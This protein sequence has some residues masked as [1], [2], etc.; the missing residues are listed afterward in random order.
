MSVQINYAERRRI[1]EFVPGLG[2]VLQ[3]TAFSGAVIHG[4]A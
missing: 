1:H 3:I 4:S 2:V